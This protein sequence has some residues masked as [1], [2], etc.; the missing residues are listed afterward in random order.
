MPFE[1]LRRSVRDRKY[2]I[3]EINNAVSGVKVNAENA[4]LSKEQRSK[5]LDKLISKLTRLKRKV[6]HA[7]SLLQ[8][9]A[10][11][12]RTMLAAHR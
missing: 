11:G 6:R 10:A 4:S 3:D 5:E 8:W 7:G 9:G 12:P 1:S 2:V